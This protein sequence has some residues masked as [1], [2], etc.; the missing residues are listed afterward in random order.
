MRI[1]LSDRGRLILTA[2]ATFVLV[3]AAIISVPSRYL[4]SIEWKWVRFGGMTLFLILYSLKTYWRQRKSVR[5]LAI[6]LGF[7]SLDLFGV[8][9]LWSIYNG[10]STIEVAIV[11]VL[12]W[13]CM[14][15]LIHWALGVGPDVRTQHPKSPWTPTL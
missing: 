9:Y 12:E 15:L 5:F 14:A 11:G 13:V 6:F 1:Q 2:L 10:L 4:N 3:A 7:L 8:G